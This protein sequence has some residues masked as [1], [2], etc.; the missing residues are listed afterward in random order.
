MIELFK[1][2]KLAILAVSWVSGWGYACFS[3]VNLMKFYEM[4]LSIQ[5]LL[6]SVIVHLFLPTLLVMAIGLLVGVLYLHPK[7]DSE[8]IRKKT[9]H[10]GA[11]IVKWNNYYYREKYFIVVKCRYFICN[12]VHTYSAKRERCNN[13][14]LYRSQIAKSIFPKTLF[15][16]DTRRYLL[17]NTI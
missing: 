2:W 1:Y 14:Y 7:W 15:A 5:I 16:S 8:Q 3:I 9:L 10:I 12:L 11:N 4:E 17:R 6:S 13:V